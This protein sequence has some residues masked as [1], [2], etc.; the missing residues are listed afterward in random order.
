MTTHAW[1]AYEKSKQLSSEDNTELDIS[2]YEVSLPLFLICNRIL[3][4]WARCCFVS[5]PWY[6]HLWNGALCSEHMVHGF[7]WWDPSNPYKCVQNV[8]CMCICFLGRGLIP[9][10]KSRKRSVT[11]EDEELESSCLLST[12]SLFLLRSGRGGRENSGWLNHSCGCKVCVRVIK[13]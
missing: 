4:P 13:D 3:W 12:S 5:A 6:V 7:N 11:P 10:I 8:L 1:A 9:F 2:R